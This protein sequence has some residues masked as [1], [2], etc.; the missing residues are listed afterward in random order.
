MVGKPEAIHLAVTSPLRQLA[1][2]WEDGTVSGV[3]RQVDA[4]LG[5]DSKR[6]RIPDFAANPIESVGDELHRHESVGREWALK[7]APS[8][9][10]S[11]SA[12]N[13]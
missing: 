2:D 11:Q 12:D 6:N 3:I 8:Q 4:M 5:S 7:R 13:R 1:A 9:R 10:K